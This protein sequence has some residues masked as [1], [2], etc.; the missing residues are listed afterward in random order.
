MIGYSA[1]ALY[2]WSNETNVALRLNDHEGSL[3]ASLDWMVGLFSTPIG[4]FLSG[5]L[6]KRMLF[7]IMTPICVCSWLMIGS[8]QSKIMLYVARVM[9][10]GTNFLL[11]SKEDYLSKPLYSSL[12]I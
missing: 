11:F 2:Q 1:I 5:L 7:L 9:S 6:G 4:G 10:G 8:A 3:F 12:P